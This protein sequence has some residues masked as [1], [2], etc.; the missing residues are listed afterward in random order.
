MGR[1]RRTRLGP[2]GVTISIE[3]P[4]CCSRPLPIT[5]SGWPCTCR[6]LRPRSRSRLERRPERDRTSR[7]A[8]VVGA[9]SVRLPGRFAA[10]LV[11]D[12]TVV[13]SALPP[14]RWNSNQGERQRTDHSGIKLFRHKEAIRHLVRDAGDGLGETVGACG[15]GQMSGKARVAAAAD[16]LLLSIAAQGDARQLDP[17]GGVPQKV[18][19]LPSGR[20]RSL[21][22][23]S[24]AAARLPRPWR[25]RRPP[26]PRGR[27]GQ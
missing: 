19:P 18:V 9:G 7:P 1:R 22:S 12:T 13:S 15:L 27:A 25:R 14:S 17:A 2:R 5:P 26:S 4:T 11:G 24:K 23:R 8:G 20:P 3:A 16:V 10:L 6:R 21:I